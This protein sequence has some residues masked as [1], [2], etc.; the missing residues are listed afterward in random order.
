MKPGNS[1]YGRRNCCWRE[2]RKL[3]S[4]I[5]GARCFKDYVIIITVVIVTYTA[6]AKQAAPS[7]RC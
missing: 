3:L 5:S 1:R 7:D 6:I 4:L 2:I